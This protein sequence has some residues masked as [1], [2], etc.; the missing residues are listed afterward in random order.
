MVLV[1]RMHTIVDPQDFFFTLGIR[2]RFILNPRETSALLAFLSIY[3]PLL[4][5]PKHVYELK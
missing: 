5:K 1:P 2:S 3:Q 4:K